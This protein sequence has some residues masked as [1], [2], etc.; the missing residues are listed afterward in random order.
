M[1][2]YNL[3][4]F[5]PGQFPPMFFPPSFV[6]HEISRGAN[7][8]GVD[9]SCPS[10]RCVSIPEGCA[11]PQIIV[12]NGRRCPFCPRNTCQDSNT[13]QEQTD[14]NQI[15]S[16]TS[17]LSQTHTIGDISSSNTISN[18]VKL[19]ERQTTEHITRSSSSRSHTNDRSSSSSRSASSASSR[20]STVLNS[21]QRNQNVIASSNPESPFYIPDINKRRI[22]HGGDRGIRGRRVNVPSSRRRSEPSS[23]RSPTRP[24]PSERPRSESTKLQQASKATPSAPKTLPQVENQQ[25]APDLFPL[26]DTSVTKSKGKENEHTQSKATSDTKA[27]VR[28][29][30]E[31]PKTTP[32][33]SHRTRAERQARPAIRVVFQ[34]M[35]RNR[36]PQ[37]NKQSNQI[38][39][40]AR[41]P[42][43][44]LPSGNNAQ[45]NRISR[46]PL[47]PFFHNVAGSPFTRVV[48][49]G[50]QNS[51][52][53]NRPNGNTQLQN[54]Q[55]QIINGINPFIPAFLLNQARI[56]NA[57][58]ALPPSSAA[59]PS[60]SSGNA[61]QIQNLRNLQHLP[62][63]FRG[64]IP[65]NPTINQNTV[66]GMANNVQANQ[67]QPAS[68]DPTAPP[69]N[70]EVQ[71]EIN[72][73]ME[74]M[75]MPIQQIL[76]N[77]PSPTQR[78]P[79][80]N[81]NQGTN[82]MALPTRLIM[83]GGQ[84]PNPQALQNSAPNQ[85]QFQQW[86]RQMALQQLARGRTVNQATPQGI[87]PN[88]TSLQTQNVNRIHNPGS[89]PINAAGLNTVNPPLTPQNNAAAS[90][91]DMTQWLNSVSQDIHRQI[92]LSANP[93]A[94]PNASPQP[95]RNGLPQVINN[96]PP[97]NGGG[98]QATGN[99]WLNRMT[100]PIH[101]EL[102]RTPGNAQTPPSSGGSDLA[103]SSWFNE[104]LNPIEQN[105]GGV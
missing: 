27:P 80:E 32:A 78:S 29:G 52:N 86:L 75:T 24:R 50:S 72:Q 56:N 49:Q 14:G 3:K 19:N 91:N 34:S 33:P 58:G 83:N 103:G 93:G 62:P 81:Q 28:Q 82:Q 79:Q 44:V 92:T 74:Q 48:Q 67:V 40:N 71:A 101:Q 9:T 69:V 20:S 7:V 13:P 31:K 97:I 18:D 54:Q 53:N 61:A 8:L 43:R 45:T 38:Q 96:T 59:V 41:L 12:I 60:V 90:N 55:R 46:M 64:L 89:R 57:N 100:Q 73:W 77:G 36:S 85:A 68:A 21:I 25:N 16:S 5:F 26:D 42:T 99:S 47:P 95:V 66:P 11:Q 63:F 76:G 30:P 1:L 51:Q 39:P 87:F 37:E 94:Q 10:F 84:T 4:T 22:V 15:V 98:N 35:N 104:M 102:T 65:F 88:P 2:T 17:E 23:Q 105:L 70:P 6:Q